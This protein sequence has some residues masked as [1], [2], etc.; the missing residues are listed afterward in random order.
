MGADFKVEHVVDD[1]H[2]LVPF[3]AIF[4]VGEDD[5]VEV[6]ETL[7]AAKEVSMM[8]LVVGIIGLA[9]VFCHLRN[10]GFGSI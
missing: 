6:P 5:E 8:L 3:V 9:S 10:R 4:L 1:A 7:W 2:V